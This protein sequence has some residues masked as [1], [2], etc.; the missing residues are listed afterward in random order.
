M[1]DE[2]VEG[3]RKARVT[4]PHSDL[5]GADHPRANDLS[6]RVVG[7]EDVPRERIDRGWHAW[8][9]VFVDPVRR[10]VSAIGENASG[11]RIEVTFG[12]VV[13][14]ETERVGMTVVSVRRDLDQPV[15]A[16]WRIAG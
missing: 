4:R 8:C 15:A 13:T 1:R 9:S 14:I 16:R 7:R 11:G 6:S 5:T 12:P 3:I 2:D 10:R